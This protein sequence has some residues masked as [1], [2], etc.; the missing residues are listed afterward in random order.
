MK[1]EETM[2]SIL[3]VT[4]SQPVT[5]S[6]TAGT[7]TQ[8]QA[9]AEAVDVAAH[10]ILDLQL[11]VV[12]LPTTVT[13]VQISIITSMQN[14]IDDVSWVT[15]AAFTWTVTPAQLGTAN[16]FPLKTF[17]L[18]FLRYVRWTATVTGAGSVSATF[19]IRG[20]ARKYGA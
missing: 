6:G 7:F 1:R 5:I 20:I 13:N 17:N 9:L 3:Q 19:W 12:N 2:G 16:A 10:D 8:S 15:V 11:G 4:P 18:G 14:Q